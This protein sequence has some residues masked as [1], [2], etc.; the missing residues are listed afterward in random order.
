[1]LAD[2]KVRRSTHCLLA[3]AAGNKIA[4]SFLPSFRSIEEACAYLLL[5]LN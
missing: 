5:L 2:S 1:M 4:F 3:S